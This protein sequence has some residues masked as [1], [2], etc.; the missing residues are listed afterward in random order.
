MKDGKWDLIQLDSITE[1][2]VK[3]YF[4]KTKGAKYDWY[5]VLGLVLGFR[6]KKNKFF[7]SEWCFNL[8]FNSS[9]GWRFNPNQ[10]TVILQ[11]GGLTNGKND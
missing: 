2:Q 4:E 10:L 9:E 6:E 5:G 3:A 1:K 11:N 8:I 7:C